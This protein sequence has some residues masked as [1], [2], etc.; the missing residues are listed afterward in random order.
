MYGEVGVI[1]MNSQMNDLN[2]TQVNVASLNV[3]GNQR[4][5]NVSSQANPMKVLPKQVINNP[6]YTENWINIKKVSNGII[7]NDI[8]EMVT[9]VKIRPKNIFILDGP[10]MDNTLIGLMNFYNTLEYEFWLIIADRPVDITMY[11]AELQLL[12]NKTQD[13]VLRK[14]INQDIDKGDYFKNNNVVDTEYYLLFKEK[15]LE[16]LQKKVRDIING[17]AGAGLVASQT[18][19][20]DLY[21]VL[22]NF[23]NAGRNYE[24]G[25]VMPS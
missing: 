6:K 23:F 14:I 1:S 10:S 8:G 16:V 13:P 11:D 24:T 15:K 18:S 4:P 20:D 17:L 25:T 7:Y 9:G 12:Y 2:N 21:M 5:V 22:D 19:N 3:T